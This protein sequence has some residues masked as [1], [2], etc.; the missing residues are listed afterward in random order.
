MLTILRISD[1]S[2]N[3]QCCHKFWNGFVWHRISGSANWSPLQSA[4]SAGQSMEIVLIK[5]DG[6]IL[7]LWMPAR[8][9]LWFD[10]TSW[11][12]SIRLIIKSC[13]KDFECDFAICDILLHWI[14]SYLFDRTFFV[15]VVSYS[16][17][18]TAALLKSHSA[19]SLDRSYSRATLRQ[20]ASNR[21]LRGWLSLERRR[22]SA[23]H[24]PYFAIVWLSQ[25]SWR[26]YRRSATVF[27]AQW[28]A[29]KLG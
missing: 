25:P 12:P 14:E 2:P 13:S 8:K 16:S 22:H 10:W 26:M 15:R 18:V 1:Q 24:S 28:L 9:S 3:L 4:Y 20:F 6:D 7:S 29:S 19:Q 27:L 5:A 23:T 21:K 11:R 17:S